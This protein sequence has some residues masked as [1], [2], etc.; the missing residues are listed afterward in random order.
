MHSAALF[1]KS[2]FYF[3]PPPE[4]LWKLLIFLSLDLH[5][6][7]FH[8]SEIPWAMGNLASDRSEKNTEERESRSEEKQSRACAASDD[9]ITAPVKDPVCLLQL[10]EARPA[11]ERDRGRVTEQGERKRKRGRRMKQD[12]ER[13]DAVSPHSLLSDMLLMTCRPHSL[14]FHLNVISAAWLRSGRAVSSF[15][16]QDTA[17]T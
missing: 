13:W 6:S 8:V 16:L 12:W 17:V 10:S 4:N 11:S 1:C 14:S 7:L 2:P 9:S 3:S 5:L 15:A